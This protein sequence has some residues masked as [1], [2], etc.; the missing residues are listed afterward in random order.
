MD[1]F[2]LVL[3]NVVFFLF[4]VPFLLDFAL[5][6]GGEWA[7]WLAYVAVAALVLGAVAAGVLRSRRG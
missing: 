2:G 5:S 6:H 3:R 7:G 4:P 1:R